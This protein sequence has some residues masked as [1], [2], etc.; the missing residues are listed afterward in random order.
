MSVSD[1]S[2]VL[3]ICIVPQYNA[4]DEAVFMSTDEYEAKWGCYEGTTSMQD[5]TTDE[6]LFSIYKE[7][8]KNY[9]ITTNGT[10][11]SFSNKIPIVL[12]TRQFSIANASFPSDS[13]ESATN[14]SQYDNGYNGV[15]RYKANLPDYQYHVHSPI[16]S[17]SKQFKYQSLWKDNDGDIV[18]IQN[19]LDKNFKE[20]SLNTYNSCN[21]VKSA[22]SGFGTAS[23]CAA[24]LCKTLSTSQT[25]GKTWDLGG[26]R[27]MSII[28]IMQMN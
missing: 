1:K 14:A 13:F 7:E 17:N 24:Y 22:I 3:A 16:C 2:K 19:P 6:S 15:M 18:C 11:Y 20:Q 5:G 10:V 8:N 28:H 21:A 25:N 4:N 27:E 9:L 26:L 23:N 12:N